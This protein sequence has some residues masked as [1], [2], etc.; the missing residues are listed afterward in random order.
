LFS[1]DIG[2][3]F[4]HTTGSN[5]R[6]ALDKEQDRNLQLSLGRNAGGV[7]T[8]QVNASHT[9]PKGS[10]SCCSPGQCT[11]TAPGLPSGAHAR[12]KALENSNG[13]LHKLGKLLTEMYVYPYNKEV[14]CDC[15]FTRMSK[16][17]AFPLHT[18]QD[19]S[20]IK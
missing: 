18:T 17:F 13:F 3:H 9:I 15:H 1:T 8:E 14:L 19:K 7:G 5:S 10:A 2:R 4:V 12:L 11:R 20:T 6:I 16:E